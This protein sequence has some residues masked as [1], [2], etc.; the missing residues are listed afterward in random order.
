[1]HAILTPVGSSGD[2]NPFI[3]IGRD[4]CRRGHRATLVAPDVFEQVARKAGIEFVSVGTAEEYDRITHDPHLWHPRRGLAVVIREITRWLR[5]GYAAIEQLHRP[6]ET[7][8]VGHS[9]SF[10]ARVFEESHRVPATT[11]HLAPS[12][13]RSDFRQ[14]IL[15]S[16]PDF[17]SWPRWAKRTV[18]WG[19]DRL[20]VDPLLAPA[21]NAWRAELGLPPVSRVFR[22]W[23]HSPQRVIGLFPDW[24]GGP[25]P[26]WPSQVRLTGFVLSDDACQEPGAGSTDASLE[27]FL[28]S[29][30]SPVVFTPGS[31]N[32][33][34]VQFFREGMD[35]IARLGCRALLVTGYRDHVPPSLPASVHHASYASFAALFPRVKAVVHHGGVGTCAQALAAGVPQVV[36]PM[37]FD[38][39]DNA[40]RL[41]RL[42]VGETIPPR[43]FSGTRVAAALDR[44]LGQNEVAVE[45][46]RCRDRI[47]E[48]KATRW[49]CDLIEEQ[50][51]RFGAC[52]GA[53]S[54]WR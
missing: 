12:V 21:L 18:W 37:G 5:R 20:A 34:A 10:F 14:P 17:T 24:F 23:I 29:G 31:A 52:A 7:I 54:D 28:L 11:I 36:M 27:H 6:N 25:Q 16:A 33:Q 47:A 19:I 39:P 15:P 26:D 2:V 44:L 9:L 13:F 30:D 35:A 3:T 22:S 46:A 53:T 32:R 50:Y 48:M 45:C 1:M 41:T 38:Q 49:A 4:L 51:D 8:V 40:A 43:R 42:K